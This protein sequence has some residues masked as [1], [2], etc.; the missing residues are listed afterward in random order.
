MRLR[1]NLTLVLTLLVVL[2]IVVSC[3]SSIPELTKEYDGKY[4]TI[5]YPESWDVVED[6]Y[7]TKLVF[8]GVM[9]QFDA[10]ENEDSELG[11]LS[12]IEAFMNAKLGGYEKLE[13]KEV[14]LMVNSTNNP[15]PSNLFRIKD[16]N[17][18]RG[19]IMFSPIDG[20]IYLSQLQPGKYK[21]S[22][23]DTAE[24]IFTSVSVNLSNW[25]A[26]KQQPVEWTVQTYDQGYW[27]FKYHSNWE[28]EKTD[29]QVKFLNSD[30]NELIQIDFVKSEEFNP[31]A[32]DALF[33]YL[34]DLNDDSIGNKKSVGEL[35]TFENISEEY[36][37][38]TNG[39]LIKIYISSELDQETISEIISS[40]NYIPEND[41]D[42]ISDNNNGSDDGN[43]TSNQNQNNNVDVDPIDNPVVRKGDTIDNDRFKIVLPMGWNYEEVSEMAS[44]IN[45]PDGN[46]SFIAIDVQSALSYAGLTLGG[47][48]EI[49]KTDPQLSISETKNVKL[50]TKDALQ[51]KVEDGEKTMIYTTY[52]NNDHFYT[53]KLIIGDKNYSNEYAAF[54]EWFETK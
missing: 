54:L 39:Q 40:F 3:G 26:Q 25:I 31:E 32:T 52:M 48:Q 5:G 8:E 36:F 21:K 1:K 46:G 30:G 42:A 4:L 20:A 24:L 2:S 13:E 28:I 34:T 16:E 10:I 27:K 19:I 47:I 41:P 45:P 7:S 49:Y 17:G 37:L 9:L 14:E 22:E 29:D 43:N 50:G 33:E 18:G 6:E 38:L 15:L 51:Y 12:K 44:F 23:L 53:I 11:D 35:V